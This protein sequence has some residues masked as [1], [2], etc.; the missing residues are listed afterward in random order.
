[1]CGYRGGTTFVRL[2]PSADFAGASPAL[3]SADG[4]LERL[5]IPIVLTPIQWAAK[6]SRADQYSGERSL[7]VAVLEDSIRSY[8]K[9]PK[10]R[11]EIRLWVETIDGFGPFAFEGACGYLDIDV[12]YLREGLIRWMGEVD[13]GRVR[14]PKRRHMVFGCSLRGAGDN[15]VVARP[16]SRGPYRPRNKG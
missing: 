4:I 14:K 15:V 6:R 3:H 11:E 13:A 9:Q 12:D 2:R 10:M 8:V 1:M 7:I 16:L 5:L